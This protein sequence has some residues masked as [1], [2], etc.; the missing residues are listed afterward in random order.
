MAV[1]GDARDNIGMRESGEAE[2]RNKAR[3]N[4]KMIETRE[5]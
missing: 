3:G 1:R 4:I 5:A 2:V